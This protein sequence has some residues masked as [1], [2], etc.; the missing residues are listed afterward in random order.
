[1]FE[2]VIRVCSNDTLLCIALNVGNGDG[3]IK[4]MRIGEWKKNNIN[5]P[6]QPCLFLINRS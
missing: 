5:L 3:Y 6:K 1:M 4:T 2:T